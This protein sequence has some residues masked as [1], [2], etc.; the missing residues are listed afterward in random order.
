V[1]TEVPRDFSLTAPV[2]EVIL[3]QGSRTDITLT[4]TSI[5]PFNSNIAFSGAFS[6]ST[7]GLTASFSPSSVI[8]QPNG[9]TEHTNLEIVAEMNTA[10]TYLLTI[11]GTS[12]NPSRTHQITL[13]VRVSPCL[14]ATATFGSELAPEVQFLRDFRDQQITNTFAGS[15]FMNVFNAWYYS[16]SPAVAQYE[17]S[18]ATVRTIAKT[19]LYPLIGALHLA[20]STYTVVAFQPELAALAA[21][22]VAGSLIGLA[23]L[24][25]PM[26]SILWVSRN[27]I[28]AR[29]K[30]RA[31]RWMASTLVA[32]IVG[33]I[34]SEIFALSVVMM[35]VS[36]GL[37]LTALGAGSILPALG[38][39]EYFR[40]KA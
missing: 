10:G 21:G 5:G 18:H 27:R 4:A 19:A 16:F 35:F 14:I 22:L 33:F 38:I 15:N 34:V 30:G 26:F 1:I 13:S 23:Y 25:L 37:V 28:D 24:T 7:P 32:L 11:T 31:A 36:G 17:Y 12:A 39:V 9:G 8:P 3:A 40:K 6:P 2:S 20:S 29:S